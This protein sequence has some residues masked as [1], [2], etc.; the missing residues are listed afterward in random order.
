MQFSY[1]TVDGRGKIE[2]GKMTADSR[3]QLLI[4]FKTQGKVA[5]EMKAVG[6]WAVR[7]PR[8]KFFDQER[9]NFTQQ[10]A[11]LLE[12]GITI[13]RALAI[14]GRLNSGKATGEL[15]KKLN[16]SLQ[17]GLSFTAALELFAR[18]FS[19]LYINMV[20]AGEAGGILPEVLQRL[21]QYLE[22]EIALNK[23]IVSSLIY[24]ALI[25]VSSVAALIFFVSDIIPKFQEI[26]AGFG[27]ALPLITRV[28]MFCGNSLTHYGW[29]MLA[30]CVLTVGWFFKIVDTPKGKM[31]F[32]RLHLQLPLIGAIQ[33]KAVIARM[34]MALSLLEH[35]GVPLLTGLQISA[36]IMGNAV[37][38]QALQIVGEEV[39][40]GRTLAQSMENQ[41]IFPALAMEM[42]SVGEESGHLGAMLGK[43]AK[44]YEAEVKNAI[45]IF[46]S[47]FEPLLILLMVGVIAILAVAILLPI[48]NLN[49]K[50]G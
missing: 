17:E 31:W 49:S 41:K 3:E 14:L 32:D 8:G 16:R 37:Y 50:M 36:A 48:V 39:R 10:L 23:F 21:A 19:P 28:V 24:P 43:V 35:S 47:V 15:I 18:D 27:S 40:A 11:G 6:R 2:C 46:L 7:V 30:V 20:R 38:T 22:D 13:E 34:A 25:V 45:G 44:T 12:S 4:L 42:I 1:K 9:L 33:K 26:F 5:L 29:M